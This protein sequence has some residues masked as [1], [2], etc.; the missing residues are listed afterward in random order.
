M[1]PTANESV[2]TIEYE[3]IDPKFYFNRNEQAS[4]SYVGNYPRFMDPRMVVGLHEPEATDVLQGEIIRAIIRAKSVPCRFK[5]DAMLSNASSKLKRSIRDKHICGIGRNIIY[6]N[7]AR[8]LRFPAFC[9]FIGKQ[10]GGEFF[11]R[12]DMYEIV[13]ISYSNML[14]MAI[15][16]SRFSPDEEYSLRMRDVFDEARCICADASMYDESPDLTID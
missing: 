6:A 11:W 2:P 16:E 10:M 4:R 14:D 7:I 8:I 5:V 9:R 15:T 12:N 1:G 3:D 13:V